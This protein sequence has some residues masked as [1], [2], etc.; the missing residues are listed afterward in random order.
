MAHPHYYECTACGS[1]MLTAAS[2]RVCPN[3]RGPLRNAGVPRA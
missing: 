1:R 2:A 3:C